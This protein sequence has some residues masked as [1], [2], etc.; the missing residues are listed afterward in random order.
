MAEEFEVRPD[1]L[2]VVAAGVGELGSEVGGVVSAALAQI[3]ARGSAWGEGALGSKFA[4][5]PDG[6]V[7]QLARVAA[8]VRAKAKL[9]SDDAGQLKEVADVAQRADQA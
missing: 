1:E 2:R 6:F 3:G 8:S 4:D 9:L 7:G 5:G